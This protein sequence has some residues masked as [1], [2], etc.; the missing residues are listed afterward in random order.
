MRWQTTQQFLL[1][2]TLENP[3]LILPGKLLN[4]PLLKLVQEITVPLARIY[5]R[6]DPKSGLPLLRRTHTC[7]HITLL[8]ERPD[9][10]EL[11]HPHTLTYVPATGESPTHPTPGTRA[12]R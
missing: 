4:H 7:E 8:S 9:P 6:P 2:A 5:L 3:H 11:R 12:N 10:F 1:I